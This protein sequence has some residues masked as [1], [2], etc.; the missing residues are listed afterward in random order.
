M[1][2]TQRGANSQRHPVLAQ[3]SQRRN[4]VLIGQRPVTVEHDGG[5]QRGQIDHTGGSGSYWAAA[6]TALAISVPACRSTRCRARPIP[7]ETP[8]AVSTSPSSTHRT[9]DRTSQLLSRPRSS[10]NAPWCV[11]AARVPAG[12]PVSRRLRR[13]CPRPYPVRARTWSRSVGCSGP[14]PA[15][16]PY[17]GDDRRL[18]RRRGPPEDRGPPAHRA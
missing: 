15:G 3:C 12:R 9:S 4:N 14:A 7:A 5:G 18:A 1:R 6:R 10:S 13:R 11:D 2:S 8:A 16:P 17:A